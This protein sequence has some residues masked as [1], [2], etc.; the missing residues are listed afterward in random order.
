MLIVAIASLAT[1]V[2][3][4]PNDNRGEVRLNQP[5]YK[6]NHNSFSRGVP[7]N[8]MVDDYNVWSIELD[9][10]WSGANVRINHDCISDNDRTLASW[11]SELGMATT[12]GSRINMIYLQMKCRSDWPERDS[13][14]ALLEVAV[15]Q[16]LGTA[17]CYPVSEFIDLDD[18]SWPSFQELNRRGYRYVVFLDETDVRRAGDS[19]AH[20]FFFG[21]VQPE[22]PPP[23]IVPSM[24][25]MEV[26]GGHDGSNDYPWPTPLDSR[27]MHRF[28][29]T[30][31]C[32]R[33]DG[34]YWETGVSRG[35]NLVATDCIDSEH[36]FDAR[37]Q[38][39]S[40]V[41]VDN[42]AIAVHQWGTHAFPFTSV[43]AGVQRASPMVEVRIHSG[44]YL[45]S[46]VATFSNPCRLTAEGGPVTI[47]H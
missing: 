21:V 44:T 39:P 18:S 4:Q 32:A 6:S 10:Y 43:A 46:G 36:T 19:L 1:S 30:E 22:N 9:L 17:A 35:F 31:N 45:L 42:R 8:I 26:R 3:A 47:G 7:L 12:A 28:Y 41:F 16:S 13:Y 33:S 15:A 24:A 25:L 34:P 11:L 38:S 27:W 29:P 40:P 23:A 5:V 20:D 2:D 14:L 37:T